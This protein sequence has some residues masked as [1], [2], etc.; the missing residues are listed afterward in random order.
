MIRLP[1]GSWWDWDVVE[2]NAGRLRLGAGHDISYAHH[3]ELVFA[4]PLFV[5]CPTTFHDPAFREPTVDEV[6][7]IAGQVGETPPVVL[8]FEAGAGGPY[9]A[10]CLIAAGQLDIV[11]GTVFRYWRELAAG[12]R[13]A[14]WV[15]P[16]DAT[17]AAA[18][19]S[20]S[21]AAFTAP[22]RAPAL[23]A[24]PWRWPRTAS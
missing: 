6:R 9:Q 23:S 19:G 17:E 20:A 18:T 7:L 1:E 22:G 10:S 8:A 12:E 13:L 14:P 16:P 5:V 15:C 11:Q 24:Q 2:W 4:D 21:A 3:L